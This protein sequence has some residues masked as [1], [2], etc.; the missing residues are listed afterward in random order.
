MSRH[1]DRIPLWLLIL[2]SLTGYILLSM[3]FPLLPHY[4]QV[5]LA[6]I[7][8]FT[9]SLAEGLAFACLLC[10]L[11]GFFALAYHRVRILNHPPG[12][13]TIV[14]VSILFSLP[15]LFTYPINAND[16]Y[17]YVIRGRIQSVYQENPFSV[18]PEEFP[19]DPFSP[20]AGEW[21]G[22]TSP[23]GPVWELAASKITL[24]TGDDLILGLLSFKALGLLAFA[25]SAVLLW[26][27]LG[28]KVSESAA[29]E[30]KNDPSSRAAYTLLWAWN[31]VLLLIFV[32]NAHND[33]LMIF[34]LLLGLAI[35]RR[36]HP[37]AGFLLMLLGAL[38]KPIGVLALPLFFV[39][40]L[41]ERQ[42][43]KERARF[44]LVSAAA[45]LLLA[46]ISFLPFGSP[47]ELVQRLIQEAAGGGGFSPTVLAILLGQ[48][49]GVSLSLTF[50][51]RV[52]LLAFSL[53]VLWLLW[54]TWRGRSAVRGTADI[55]FGY[56][57][58]ALNFRIWYAA[59]PFPWLLLDAGRHE[60]DY[61]AAF[62]LRY[63]LW[64]LLTT[65]LS[66]IIYGHIRV[67]LLG[68]DQW[69]AHLVGVLFVFVS[70][71]FLAYLGGDGRFI[72]RGEKIETAEKKR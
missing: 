1:L 2:L 68:G 49:I 27:M 19:D 17:R 51:S 44:L 60:A 72:K 23:Y 47:L 36:G 39:S 29:A 7:R 66:V 58:Q 12:L 18:A 31:P 37:E 42:S 25:G 6:D 21:A 4:N 71:F 54:K 32:A 38:T 46:I 50:V 40:I 30:E 45:G 33:A 11:F 41:R 48:S 53:F 15:M 67:Y 9:P 5:P 28:S 56:L 14:G 8:F 63:G 59:W 20:L 64:F 16:I 24:I 35:L 62:R 70:P 65:Q 43:G 69:L 26:M 52:T 22:V 55:F 10:L 13:T 34:W 57:L 61:R 3:W